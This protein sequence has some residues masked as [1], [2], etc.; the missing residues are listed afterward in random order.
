MVPTEQA[1][2]LHPMF[3]KMVDAEDEAYHYLA[4]LKRATRVRYLVGRDSMLGDVICQ[5]VEDYNKLHPD[6]P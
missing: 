1:N 4:E 2:S 6:S 5:G 3:Q